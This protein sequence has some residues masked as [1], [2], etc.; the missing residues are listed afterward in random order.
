MRNNFLHIAG[1]VPSIIFRV[2]EYGFHQ[3]GDPLV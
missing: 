1:G 3:Y 2:G